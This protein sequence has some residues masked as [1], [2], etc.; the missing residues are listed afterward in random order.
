MNGE[1]RCELKRE[2]AFY[3]ILTKK[4]FGVD[5]EMIGFPVA[6]LM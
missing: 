1:G 2:R 5:P 4:Q 3:S 6:P